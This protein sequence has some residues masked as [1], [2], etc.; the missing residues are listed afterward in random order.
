MYSAYLDRFTDNQ[1]A[2]ILI[3]ELQ[4]EFQIP[5]PSLPSGC[6]PGD[7]LTVEIQAG[8]ITSIQLDSLK[9]EQK[10]SEIQNRMQRLRAKKKSRF[11]RS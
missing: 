3:D 6:T 2:I 5:I 10:K 9:T 8:K 7:W 4:Q 1:L 11:K